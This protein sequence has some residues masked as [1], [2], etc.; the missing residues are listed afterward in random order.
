MRSS[1][2]R[3]VA[4]NRCSRHIEGCCGSLRLQMPVFRIPAAHVFPDPNLSEQSG[5]LGVGGDLHPDR[6][7]LAYRMGIFPWYSRG[8]PILWWSPDPRFVLKPSELKVARSLKKTVRKGV[9][10]IRMDTAFKQVMSECRHVK[11]PGQSGTWI[12]SAMEEAYT[13]LHERG[14]AHSAEAWK[15]GELVGGLYGVSFGSFFA[16]ESMFARA[17]DA[18]KVT[19]VHFCRQLERW[20]F[21]LIDCQ[22]RTDHLERFGAYDLDRPS[23]LKQLRIAL[24]APTRQGPWSFDGQ[25]PL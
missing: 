20:N 2:K 12:D 24:M 16:G 4:V 7:E 1:E 19:W 21:T 5:L 15:D 23:Y 6:V 9:Y 13:A 25:S 11:R 14:I 10:E 22:V 18:S 3:V 8:E 17:P